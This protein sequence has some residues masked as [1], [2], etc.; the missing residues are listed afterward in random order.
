MLF[1][2][3][4][5]PPLRY[6]SP[7]LERKFEAL[8]MRMRKL[9][10]ERSWGGGISIFESLNFH[11]YVVGVE[12]KI[13]LSE[14]LGAERR[15]GGEGF[16]YFI[17]INIR[18][19]SRRSDFY[20]KFSISNAREESGRVIGGTFIEKSGWMDACSHSYRFYKAS[21]RFDL[22]NEPLNRAK[23]SVLK[24]LNR[25]LTYPPSLRIWESGDGVRKGGHFHERFPIW[26]NFFVGDW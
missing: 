25:H 19:F 14:I 6:T 10:G 22:L 8:E 23:R 4:S 15:R 17:F 5:S 7:N 12:I 24:K 1:W 2:P 13:F 3:S 16:A 18:T 9:T 11:Y 26:V 21:A 20:E